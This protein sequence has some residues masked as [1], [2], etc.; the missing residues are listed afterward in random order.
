M[1]YQARIEEAQQ[2]AANA[3]RDADRAFWMNIVR[4]WLNLSGLRR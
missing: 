3:V 1:D 4:C 2:F